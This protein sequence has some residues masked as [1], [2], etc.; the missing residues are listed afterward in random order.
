MS[1]EEKLKCH[2]LQLEGLESWPDDEVKAQMMA[3]VKRKIKELE[4]N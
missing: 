3:W 4:M 1:R 2:R